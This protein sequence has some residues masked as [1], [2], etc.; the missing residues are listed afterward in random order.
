MTCPFPGCE[1][2]ADPEHVAEHF[3][4]VFGEAVTLVSHNEPTT[5]DTERTSA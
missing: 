1:H 2:P 4:L 3:S 5:P